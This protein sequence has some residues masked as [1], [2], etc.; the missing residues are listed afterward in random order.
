MTLISE[1]HEI[2]E[3][4]LRRIEGKPELTKPQIALINDKITVMTMVFMS[5]GFFLGPMI[6]GALY[7]VYG[8][9][10]TCTIIAW[11]YVANSAIFLIVGICIIPKNRLLTQEEIDQVREN[12]GQQNTGNEHLDNIHEGP[13]VV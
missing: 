7:D 3:K 2:E 4:N 6:G 1:H 11:I 13:Q 12:K 5:L 9:D 8:F 10:K